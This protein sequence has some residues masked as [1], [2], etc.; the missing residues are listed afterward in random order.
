MDGVNYNEVIEMSLNLLDITVKRAK[1]N[2]ATVFAAL[3]EEEGDQ[4]LI[5]ALRKRIKD[6]DD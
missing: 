4:M 2:P 5:D 1:L 6:S 3:S